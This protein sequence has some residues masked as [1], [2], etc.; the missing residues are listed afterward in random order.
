M[1]ENDYHFTQ[2][3]CRSCG[4]LGKM[5]GKQGVIW[6]EFETFGLGV[7]SISP[8][9][10]IEGRLGPVKGEKAEKEQNHSDKGLVSLRSR[11]VTEKSR[12]WMSLPLEHPVSHSSAFP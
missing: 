12:G 1:N 4:D 8:G 2:H 11:G 6:A 9:A 10:V 3:L 7:G 5:S